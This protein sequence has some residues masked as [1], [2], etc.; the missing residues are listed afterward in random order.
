MIYHTEGCFGCTRSRLSVVAYVVH[1]FLLI[2]MTVQVHFV[3][4]GTSCTKVHLS[5]YC[6]QLTSINL[7]RDVNGLLYAQLYVLQINNRQL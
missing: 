2:C 5:G 6:P 7:N 3:M 1:A 4:F